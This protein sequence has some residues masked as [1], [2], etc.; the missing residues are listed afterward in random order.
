MSKKSLVECAANAERKH[1]TRNSGPVLDRNEV[2][3]IR[4]RGW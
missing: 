3:P 1:Y 2:P 4:S